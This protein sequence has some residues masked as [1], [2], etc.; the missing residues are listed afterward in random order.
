LW[1]NEFHKEPSIL[2]I[3]IIISI[4]REGFYMR[5]I[6]RVA[7]LFK[8]PKDISIE[9]TTQVGGYGA[10]SPKELYMFY[11]LLLYWYFDSEAC[12]KSST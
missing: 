2:W 6:E 4:L 5:G 10:H 9:D 11:I 8:H 3:I 1:L 12:P 7:L